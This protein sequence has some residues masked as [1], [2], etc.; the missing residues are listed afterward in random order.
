MMWAH[1]LALVGVIWASA[2]LGALVVAVAAAGRCRGCRCAADLPALEEADDVEVSGAGG[3]HL[4]G[5]R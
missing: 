4:A 5:W 1:W 2:S 3:E